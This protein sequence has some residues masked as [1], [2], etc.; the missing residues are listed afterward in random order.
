MIVINDMNFFKGLKKTVSQ[1][2]LLAYVD[3]DTGKRKVL[4]NNILSVFLWIP[5][6]FYGIGMILSPYTLTFIQHIG[7]FLSMY[8]FFLMVS[9]LGRYTGIL[10]LGTYKYI[11]S[12]I[13]HKITK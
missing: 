3:K 7:N 11:F 9:L 12:Y 10:Y 2:S 5:F 4:L 8:F 1:G 6:C 13:F